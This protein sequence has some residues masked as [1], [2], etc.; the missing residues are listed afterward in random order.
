MKGG[1]GMRRN[2]KA[3]IDSSEIMNTKQPDTISIDGVEIPSYYGLWKLLR[4]VETRI[5]LFRNAVIL[6]GIA[7]IAVLLRLLL[8]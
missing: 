5:T 6:E 2:I 4:E 1:G 3:E 7:I 8:M